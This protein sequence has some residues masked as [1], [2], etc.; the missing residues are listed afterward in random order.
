MQTM[1]G[2]YT[3]RWDGR[4]FTVTASFDLTY[5]VI[6]ANLLVVARPGTE[7]ASVW[8]LPYKTVRYLRRIGAQVDTEARRWMFRLFGRSDWADYVYTSNRYQ[9]RPGTNAYHSPGGRTGMPLTDYSVKYLWEYLYNRTDISAWTQEAAS[10]IDGLYPSCISNNTYLDFNLYT[11]K[12][13][14]Q[15]W[16]DPTP[17]VSGIFWTKSEAFL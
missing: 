4:S 8:L 11:T 2:T 10:R 9:T 1:T 5:P 15:Y 16:Q 7:N 17:N 13:F 6:I 12:F 14:R 3:N